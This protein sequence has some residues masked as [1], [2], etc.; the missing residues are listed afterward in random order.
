MIMMTSPHHIL[1]G[2]ELKNDGIGGEYSTYGKTEME[3]GFW[4]ENL[5]ERDHL[6]DLYRDGGY[7]NG[8]L[9]RNLHGSKQEREADSCDRGNELLCSPECSEVVD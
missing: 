4:W 1:I 2:Y 6:E 5:I 9:I 3:T 7:V 8:L